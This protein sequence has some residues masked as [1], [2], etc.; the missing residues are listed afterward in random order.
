MS[1]ALQNCIRTF[2]LLLFA[3]WF[4]TSV[5][6]TPLPG[7]I[8]LEPLFEGMV[9][10]GGA[11]GTPDAIFGGFGVVWNSAGE[12]RGI[13]EFDLDMPGQ[14]TGG[15]IEVTPIGYS[16][17]P[18]TMVQTV[19]LF[20]FAGDGHLRLSDFASGVYVASVLIPIGSMEPIALDVGEFLTDLTGRYA[21]FGFRLA[22]PSGTVNFGSR[23]Y[24]PRP[25][26]T[27][28]ITQIREPGMRWVFLAG[29]F[30]LYV[31]RNG[32]HRAQFARPCG[33]GA[34]SSR[35]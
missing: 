25:S 13:L 26:L 22:S 16:H 34:L 6:A 29:L 31:S 30:M 4:Q 32:P 23:G 14:I 2:S 35:P 33:R 20:G 5:H 9:F 19:H 11:D 21:G 27:V 17:P 1:G 15:V 10:D 7:P 28:S 3:I 18:G 24:P 12:L 8:E